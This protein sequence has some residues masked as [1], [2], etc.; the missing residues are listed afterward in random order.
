MASLAVAAILVKLRKGF[1]T[2]IEIAKKAS[3]GNGIL[4]FRPLGPRSKGNLDSL[5]FA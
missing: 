3:K 4:R 1:P 5:V 2:W